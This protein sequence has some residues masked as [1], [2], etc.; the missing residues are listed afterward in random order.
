[1][2]SIQPDRPDLNPIENMFQLLPK[3]LGKD[4]VHDRPI[5]S[6]KFSVR[7]SKTIMNFPKDIIDTTIKSLWRSALQQ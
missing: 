2:F 5:T 7:V 1:M 3:P 6:S 4:V